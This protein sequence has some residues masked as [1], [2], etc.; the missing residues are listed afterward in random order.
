MDKACKLQIS[1]SVVLNS[2][3][4]ISGQLDLA[5]MALCHQFLTP[6][7]TRKEPW[8]TGL[9]LLPGFR[10]ETRPN[11]VE[12]SWSRIRQHRSSTEQSSSEL[13]LYTSSPDWRLKNFT[14]EEQAVIAWN[15][16]SLQQYSA[17][18]HL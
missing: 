9:K 2:M 4:V 8:G 18:S 5:Q 3:H 13:T 11:D 7:T 17:Y 12:S 16:K 14:H 6:P 10:L 15:S 1:T